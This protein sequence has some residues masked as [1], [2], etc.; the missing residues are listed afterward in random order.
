M[1]TNLKQGS[2]GSEVKKMQEALIEAG[3]DVGGT[4][5][6]GVF[7]KN[8]LAAV[9]Q[10]QKDNGL[11]VDGIAGKNTL[12]S[13]YSTGSSSS[14]SGSSSSGTGIKGK[15]GVAGATTDVS[16]SDTTT[17]TDTSIGEPPAPRVTSPTAYGGM[18][19]EDIAT[20][21]ALIG[22]ASNVLQQAIS[23]KPGDYLSKYQ[24]QLDDYWNQIQNR[25]PFSYD[26]NSD[27]LY[28]QYKD[29]Y[30]QQGQM[31]MMDTMGQATT[32]TGGYGNSYAQTV[33]QQVYNQYLGQLNEVMPELYGMAYDQYRQEGQDLVNQYG[34]LLDMENQ[35]YNRYL[36]SVN[37][38]NNEV[39]QARDNYTSLYDEYV[40]AYDQTYLEDE[41]ERKW[42]YTEKQDAKSDLID[43]IKN[44]GYD[45][46]DEELAAAGIT[47]EQANGYKKHYADSKTSNT[48]VEPV[49]PTY[50]KLT[51]EEQQK[52]TK[53]FE[54]ATSLAAIEEVGDR[55]VDAGFDPKTVARWVD[56][57]AADLPEKAGNGFTG[58][59]Y[60]EATEYLRTHGAS[61][62]LIAS[63]MTNGEW[64]KHK[65][66]YSTYEE[67]LKAYVKKAFAK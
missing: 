49:K 28:N 2:S 64:A 50:E 47:K 48:T 42:E 44:T 33:G 39:T 40:G 5:A 31:A 36:D 55:M 58:T 23:S 21:K 60:A 22:E 62:D 12:G 6:D 27:A 29:Q 32:M 35:D 10:Y 45:P 24:T 34:M 19:A 11:A 15:T 52:W 51:Y 26:F 8:T 9:K 37:L 41:N 53:E 7:G 67:Y 65:G 25:D 43:L 56:G 54:G 59:T 18:T 57:Y 20:Y 30:I 13:L 63:V 38:W 1:A 61:G 66:G 46:T 16:K 17:P 14:S 3:Y 4:G